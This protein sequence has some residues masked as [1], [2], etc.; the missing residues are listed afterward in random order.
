MHRSAQDHSCQRNALDA[1]IQ[2]LAEE[3]AELPVRLA[4]ECPR[5]LDEVKRCAVKSESP[6]HGSRVIGVLVEVREH[7]HGVLW[8]R[9]VAHALFARRATAAGRAVVRDLPQG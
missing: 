9:H 3:T 8:I 1:L 4:C 7:A 6:L 2:L 5:W